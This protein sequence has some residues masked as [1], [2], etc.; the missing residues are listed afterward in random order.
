MIDSLLDKLNSIN[1]SANSLINILETMN[2]FS[3]GKFDD[4]IS[5]LQ[6]VTSKINSAITALNTVKD[7]IANGQQPNLSLLNNV[8][9]FS[10]ILV[11]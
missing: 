1:T 4:I 10:M 6:T 7:N 9:A 5:N 11:I 2:K 3:P 8:I